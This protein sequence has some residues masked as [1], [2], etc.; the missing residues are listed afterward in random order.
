[1]EVGEMP[2]DERLHASAVQ[3]LLDG[4]EEDAANVLLSCTLQISVTN[5]N[6]YRGSKE[7][8]G[9]EVNVIGPRTAYDI[10]SN[11]HHSVT[12]AVKKAIDAVL[13]PNFYVSRIIASARLVDIDP[14]WKAE[15]LEIAHGRGVYNQGVNAIKIWNNLRFR[16]VSEIRIAEVLDKVGVMFLPNCLARLTTPEGGKNR[17][18]DFLVCFNG[19]WGILEVDGEPFHPATRTVDDH[20]RDR[21]FH[22]HGIQVVEH[23]DA[24]ECYSNPDRV[25]REFLK[26]LK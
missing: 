10:L 7:L 1:M 23:F 2:S 5:D 9:V 12:Q 18:A 24:S 4:H 14:A 15:L 26:L 20:K 17:E 6:W 19:N 11:S 13:P 16:S 3:F 25:V 8:F 21:L 22:S